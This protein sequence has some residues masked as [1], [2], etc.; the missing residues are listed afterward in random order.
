[1]SLKQ[2]LVRALTKGCRGLKKRVII[3][4]KNPIQTAAAIAVIT[5]PT[6]YFLILHFAGSIDAWTNAWGRWAQAVQVAVLSGPTFAVLRY[7]VV[8][9]ASAI[10]S[11]VWGGIKESIKQD[12]LCARTSSQKVEVMYSHS[13][14]EI[15][16]TELNQNGLHLKQ[17]ISIGDDLSIVRLHL[18]PDEQIMYVIV[19]GKSERDYKKGLLSCLCCVCCCEWLVKWICGIPASE[20]RVLVIDMETDEMITEMLLDKKPIGADMTSNGEQIC[21]IHEEK[22]NAQKRYTLSSLYPKDSFWSSKVVGALPLEGTPQKVTVFTVDGNPIACVTD[23]NAGTATFVQLTNH[24][25]ILPMD[26]NVGP[27]Q[28]GKGP[29]QVRMIPDTDL[30]LVAN[31]QANTLTFFEIVNGNRRLAVDRLNIDLS[32]LAEYELK[33]VSVTKH[34]DI[35]VT[36]RDHAGHSFIVTF[37]WTG[38]L[39]K[40]VEVAANSEGLVSS[41]EG[42][43]ECTVSKS[44]LSEKITA[45]DMTV[46]RKLDETQID[47]NSGEEKKDKKG[48]KKENKAEA[49]KTENEEEDKAEEKEKNKEKNKEKK[50]GHESQPLLSKEMKTYQWSRYS[51]VSVGDDQTKYT[52]P[53]YRSSE[54]TPPPGECSFEAMIMSPNGNVVCI[55]VK[56]QNHNW[57]ALALY[58]ESGKLERMWY[59]NPRSGIKGAVIASV[60]K[61]QQAGWKARIVPIILAVFLVLEVVLLSMGIY[62]LVEYGHMD[63]AKL[64]VRDNPHSSYLKFDLAQL[65][66]LPFDRYSGW[67]NFDIKDHL[68]Q[69]N[70]IPVANGPVASVLV[71]GQLE[72]YVISQSSKVVSVIDIDRNRMVDII[73][74]AAVPSN[75]AISP[76]GK[77]AWILS[78]LNNITVIEVATRTVV[79]LLSLGSNVEL[80]KIKFRPDGELAWVVGGNR[81]TVIN[82]ATYEVQKKPISVGRQSED[83]AL[84]IDGKWILVPSREDNLIAVIDAKNQ[85]GEPPITAGVGDEP[86][87]IVT[88]SHKWGFVANYISGTV[89][90]IDTDE[91]KICAN[92]SVPS[93]P[94]QLLLSPDE[95]RVYGL[96][97]RGQATFAIEIATQSQDCSANRLIGL[98]SLPT[99]PYAMA[100]TSDGSRIVVTHEWVPGRGG[101]ISIVDATRIEDL[102]TVVKTIWLKGRDLG[103]P[104]LVNQ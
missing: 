6:V 16:V 81:T 51:P 71:S 9:L 26:N 86:W 14:H 8:P 4:E 25:I 104:I 38:V 65:E 31:M 74:L 67:Y 76:N 15:Y 90:V 21:M 42:F 36:V 59:E 54:S 1:M 46:I 10:V 24:Q 56:L 12:R 27:Q 11:F 91:M 40:K 41:E 45:L 58:R 63:K 13:D 87:F 99:T 100:I 73:P 72:I 48:K 3:A 61:K 50:E 80:K 20:G 29:T 23:P 85:V 17:T 69:I 35:Q 77:Y 97:K 53:L 78:S 44:K 60:N 19:S 95:K 22:V 5:L 75:V 49:D 102:K 34:R 33:G 93:Q 7:G 84:T 55:L 52:V 28:V 98:A 30:I 94:Y 89:S 64:Y 92:I 47:A 43:W 101:G 18:L 62:L 57:C 103:E 79:T 82:T 2:F 39:P 32:F 66:T 70:V 37:H 88:S 83:I 96:A 68:D